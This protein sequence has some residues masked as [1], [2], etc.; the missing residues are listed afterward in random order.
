MYDPATEVCAGGPDQAGNN[1]FPS[2][3]S[4]DSGGPL[5]LA[6]TGGPWTDR[7]LGITDYGSPLGCDASP[8]VFQDVPAHLTWI[9]GT[10]GLG[11]V[12]V[13]R[14]RQTAAGRTIATISVW[15]RPSEA[16]TTIAVLNPAGTVSA[17]V[18]AQAWHRAPVRLT[19]RG[20]APGAELAGISS[21]HSQC[22]RHRR[23]R[24]GQSAYPR[25]VSG[26]AA[27]VDAPTD[28]TQVRRRAVRR[29]R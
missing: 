8:S 2:V 13:L 17:T 6:G 1:Q 5:I 14:A 11:P 28:P 12:G 4:G 16:R 9:L 15:L 7:L 27:V 18:R 19:V 26:D 10:T 29:R 24:A 20:L 21:R 3:C 22:L 23:G 25:Q